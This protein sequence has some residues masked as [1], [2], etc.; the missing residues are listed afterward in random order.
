[1]VEGKAVGGFD[2][3]CPGEVNTVS[4]AYG[5]KIGHWL[6]QIQRRRPWDAGN[7]AGSQ[8]RNRDDA[9][10]AGMARQSHYLIWCQMGNLQNGIQMGEK[11]QNVISK[12]GS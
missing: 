3:C 12:T 4:L 1:M 7:A 9:Q 5:P 11:K 8:S 6:R 2:R 10:P